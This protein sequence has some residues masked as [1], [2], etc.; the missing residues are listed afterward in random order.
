[1]KRFLTIFAACASLTAPAPLWAQSDP[2][3]SGD[4]DPVAAAAA[5]IPAAP[6]QSAE[7][8]DLDAL[9][10]VN[11]VVAVFA[12]SPNDPRFVQQMALIED[13]LD[14]LAERDVVVVTDTDPAARSAV[15]T[16]LRARRGFAL[17]VLSK[18]GTVI[19]RKPSPRDVR[20][21][22]RSIDKLP[23]RQQELRDRRP[24]GPLGNE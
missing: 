13:R 15:R 5:P 6:I 2:L 17:M 18:E 23:L 10:W 1:M 22:S 7:A 21:I 9:L 16:S 19:F 12:D 20:E 4:A 11:R 14:A 24:V 8:T 3:P